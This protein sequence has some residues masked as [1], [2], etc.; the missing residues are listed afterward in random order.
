MFYQGKIATS[1]LFKIFRS[2]SLKA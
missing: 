2:R 1:L